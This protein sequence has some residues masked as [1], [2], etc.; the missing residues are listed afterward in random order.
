MYINDLEK[1]QLKNNIV[2]SLKSDEIK[3]RIDV[4]RDNEILVKADHDVGSA[5]VVKHLAN[6]VIAADPQLAVGILVIKTKMLEEGKE[7]L[8][9]N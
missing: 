1:I 8:R 9:G 6:E 2:N 5:P 4:Q 3:K 7:V